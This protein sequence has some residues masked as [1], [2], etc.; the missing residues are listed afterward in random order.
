MDKSETQKPQVLLAEDNL[1][2][3]IVAKAMLIRYNCDVDC[4]SNGQEAVEAFVRNRYDLILMDCQM[5]VMDGYDATS[6]IRSLEK[7]GKRIPILAVTAN[8]GES[9]SGKCLGAGMDDYLAKPFQ[10]ADLHAKL[11]QLL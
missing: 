6:E 9:E 8:A 10:I 4:V 2:N 7:D 1:N 5:P 11:A 3:R